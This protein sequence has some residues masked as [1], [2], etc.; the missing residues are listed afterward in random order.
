MLK[1]EERVMNDCQGKGM[2]A[3]RVKQVRGCVG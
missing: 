2:K 3:R 1:I